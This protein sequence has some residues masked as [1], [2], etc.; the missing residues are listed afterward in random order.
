MVE[1]MSG[2]GRKYKILIVDDDKF[3]LNMYEL[4]FKKSGHEVIPSVS[5]DDA[6]SK[7]RDGLV[8][9]IILIDV[10]LPSMDGFEFLQTIKKEKLAENATAIMLTNLG[11][12]EEMEKAKKLGVGG[13][14]IKASEVPSQIVEKV[15]K[16]ANK[17]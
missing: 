7:L 9:D 15:L 3:L 5:S 4:K 10:V 2:S 17:K 12:G 1:H 13:Y 14:I 8:P 16:I 11:G 6:L